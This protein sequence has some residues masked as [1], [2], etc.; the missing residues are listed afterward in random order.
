MKKLAMGILFL[1]FLSFSL[2]AT[3]VSL[4]GIENQGPEINVLQDNGSRIVLEYDLKG[5][6]ITPMVID[7]R[8]C[9]MVSLPGQVTFMEKGMPKLPTIARNII[10]PDDARMDIRVVDIEYEIREVGTI[11]PSRGSFSRSIDPST[12]PYTFD[13]FYETDS[14]WPKENVEILEPFILREYRG[15]TVRFNPFQYNPARGELRVVKRIVVEVFEVGKGGPNVFTGKR[16][17]LTRDFVPIYRYHFLNYPESRYPP[18]AEDAGRMVIICADAYMSNMASFVTWKRQKGI[19]TDIVPVS[20]IGNTEPNIKSYIQTEYNAGGLVWVV[21]VGDGNEVEPATGTIGWAAGAATDNMYALTAGGDNYL[22]LFISRMSSRGSATNIDK[23]VSRSIEYEKTP[24]TGASWYHV[25]LGVASAQD[26]GTG[27][28]DST[29][30]NFLRDSLLN[31][32][33]TSVNKSYDY[34]G[35]STMIKGFIEAGTSIINYIGHGSPSGWSNGGGFNIGNI[36]NLNNPWM[37]PFVLSVACDVGDFDGYDCYCEASVTAGTVGS[38]DGFLVHWGSTI[39]QHW[40][41]PCAG[42][43]GAVGLLVNDSRNTFGGICFNGANYMV[44]VFGNDDYAVD[45]LQTWE[46]FGDA[47]IQLRTDTPASIT[48]NHQSAIY[49]GNPTFDVQVVGV[50]DALCALFRNDTLFGA[51]YTDGSGT[52]TITLNP[53]ITTAGDVTL[54][55][56][57]Y[58]KIPY[59][60]TIPAQGASGPYI[61]F[62]KGIIDDSGGNNNGR[63]NPGETIDLTAWAENAGIGAGY[64]VYALFDESDP[65]VSITVD[66]T[67]FGTIDAGDSAGGNPDYTFNVSSNCPDQHS[68]VFDF[69]AHDQNDTIWESHPAFT[70]YAPVLVLNSFVIDPSGNQRLDPGETV[71]CIVTLDNTGSEDAT[72]V[73]GYLFESNSYI[74]VPDPNANFGTINSGNSGNNSSNPFSVT[75]SPSTPIGE[76]VTF[77]LEVTSGTYVD[78]V[79]FVVTVGA[80]HYLIWDADPNTSSGP[81]IDAALQSVGFVGDYSTS[82]PLTT[83][84]EYLAIFVCV[85]IFS[86]NYVIPDGGAEATALENFASS[87]GRLYLEGGDVWYY[88][89]IYQGGHDFGPL[90][91]IN[92]TDDGSSDL[93]TI[94]GQGGTFTTGMSFSYSGENSWIDHISPTGS[95]SF[96]IFRNSSPGYDNGVA[97]DAGTYRTVG[98]SFEFGGLVDGSPPSTKAALADSIMHF[99]GIFIGVEEKPTLPSILPTVYHLSQSYPNPCDNQTII[100]YQIPR[101]GQVSL[102]VYDATGR[103]VEVLIDGEIEPGYHS[104]RLDTKGYASGIYF[105][106]LSA[107]GRTFTKKMIVVK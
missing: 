92:P 81:V 65:Y 49:F 48:V 53:V 32:T 57:A 51:A 93:A 41:E 86:D 7:E 47:S 33:Y 17:T 56:T 14:W 27:Y 82:L 40:V 50:E 31:Y 104:T 4:G 107:G 59:I 62:Q 37:L 52:A 3:W 106:R 6:R 23:Q 63:I 38:P 79:E 68:I 39:S 89:P 95:G 29:R 54:T 60:T 13:T 43:A 12:I 11:V 78:T 2:S 90:F 45:M 30:A 105:Y 10:I 70:V 55:V 80:K 83:L 101:K 15:I 66:S 99:F 75:A 103:L 20:S 9:E 35:T 34:W 69:E 18:I 36:N 5:Y 21:L 98:T 88:D 91:G 16:E 67:Y 26:G 84:D 87:G 76:S 102:N 8:A 46:I 73:T 58:N 71:D 94:Q 61:N 97:R 1:F 85:G 42:Q 72:S 77:K 22:D 96:L 64:G 100:H 25:G 28:A 74:S 19:E 44:E 24:Q